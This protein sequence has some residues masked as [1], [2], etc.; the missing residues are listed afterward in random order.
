MPEQTLTLKVR[1][2]C[3]NDIHTDLL[4]LAVVRLG[5]GLI[6]LEG[7]RCNGRRIELVGLQWWGNPGCDCYLIDDW[8]QV[9]GCPHGTLQRTGGPLSLAELQAAARE[10]LTVGETITPIDFGDNCGGCGQDADHCQCQPDLFG[11]AS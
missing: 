7:T 5:S 1:H 2:A 10:G 3:H 11:E 9:P 4:T 8:P 6:R